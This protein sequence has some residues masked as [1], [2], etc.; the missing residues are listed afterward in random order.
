MTDGTVIIG[1]GSWREG[2]VLS[3]DGH[4]GEVYAGAVA[5]TH[6]IV[7]EAAVLLAWAAEL[8]ID[9]G[10]GEVRTMDD[11]PTAPGARRGHA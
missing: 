4:S 1:G 8:G 3:I 7:P 10:G 2:D 11:E 6:S 9:I 5:A